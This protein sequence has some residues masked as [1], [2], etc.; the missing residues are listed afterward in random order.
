MR[1]LYDA[2]YKISSQRFSAPV[3]QAVPCLRLR[4]IGV[5]SL[6]ILQTSLNFYSLFSPSSPLHRH[7]M[8]LH[9]QPIGLH[10]HPMLLHPTPML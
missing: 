6:M 9:P 5:A 3:V 2:F 10:R 7:P 4:I 1:R 8:L